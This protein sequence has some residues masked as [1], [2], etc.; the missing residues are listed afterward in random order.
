MASSDHF[1]DLRR[2]VQSDPASIAF[3]Q[4]AEEQ[5]RIGQ[6]AEAVATC[7]TGLATH[8]GFTSARVTLGRA[9]LA[10]GQLEEAATELQT[11]VTASPESL[12]AVRALADTLRQQGR[13]DEARA[14]YETALKLAPNDPDLDRIVRG[15]RS[16]G[17]PTNRG[18][19]ASAASRRAAAT[20][21]ALEKLAEAIHATRTKSR[22]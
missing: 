6:L 13:L 1:E 14:R 5:R 4:L 16:T 21:A 18:R 10:L 20:V 22:A 11:A 19:D 17:D 2:R 8:P 9:L 3:A 12:A 15:L 7:R